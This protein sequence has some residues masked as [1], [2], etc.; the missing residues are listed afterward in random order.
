MDHLLIIHEPFADY[1]RFIYGHS[2]CAESNEASFTLN[3]IWI[4]WKKS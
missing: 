1:S 4:K 2:R 3:R